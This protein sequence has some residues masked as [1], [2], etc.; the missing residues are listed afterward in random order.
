MI[1]GA[2]GPDWLSGLELKGKTDRRVIME[3]EVEVRSILE[4]EE[5]KKLETPVTHLSS[6]EG[7]HISHPQCLLCRVLLKVGRQ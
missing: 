1:G 2:L 5:I 4:P 3:T 7:K 6:E